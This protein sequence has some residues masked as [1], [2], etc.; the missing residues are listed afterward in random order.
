MHNS[1]PAEISFAKKTKVIS[2]TVKKYKP[3]L[4]VLDI[5]ALGSIL[6]SK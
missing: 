3:K 2:T 4:F 1:A 5:T 6:G